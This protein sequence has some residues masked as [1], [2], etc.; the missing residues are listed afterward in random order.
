MRQPREYISEAVTSCSSR[1]YSGAVQDTLNQLSIGLEKKERTH[2][3]EGTLHIS[4]NMPVE[5]GE[6][7]PRWTAALRQQRNGKAQA[8]YFPV[9]LESIKNLSSKNSESG[10]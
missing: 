4:R 6:F 7:P 5:C 1:A 10:N 3:I 2:I 9:P 8:G